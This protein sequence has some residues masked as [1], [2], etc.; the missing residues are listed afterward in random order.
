VVGRLRILSALTGGLL[1]G[2]V[3]ITVLGGVAFGAIAGSRLQAEKMTES[4]GSIS[5]RWASGARDSARASPSVTVPTGTTVDQ[6]QLFTRQASANTAEFAIYVDGTAAANKVGTFRPPA[7][8]TWGISTVNL[9][10]AIGPGVHTLYIGP[11][12]TFSNN[13]FIDW[14]KLHN[15]GTT[16]PSTDTDTDGVPDSSD[17]C[18]AVANA[19]QADTD[20]DSVGDAC[21]TTQPPTGETTVNVRDFGATGDGTSNDT[22][23]FERAMA[24]AARVG[25]VAYV[26]APGNYRIANVNPPSNTRLQVQA[27][28]S[29]KKYGSDNG[30]LFSVHGP[31]DTTF[32]NNVHIEGVGGTFNIDLSDAGSDT[33]GIRYRNVRNFSLRNMICIQN[34]DNPSQEDPS[35][36]K[37]CIS[38]LPQPAGPVNGVYNHPID[39]V[40]E[41][42][43]S[44]RSPYGWGLTQIS[45]GENVRFFD[46]SSEGGVPLRL[47]NYSNN[48]TPMSNI[49][50]DGVTC[51]DGHDAVH[52]NP[53]GARHGKVTIR[54]VVADSCESALSLKGDGSFGADST[55]TG[56]TVIP[57]NQA[58]LRDEATTG[59]VGAWVIGP[60]RW[61]IDN[62]DPLGYTISLLNVDCGDLSNRRP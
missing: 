9:S 10:T 12:A 51:K 30:P 6:I 31:N 49:V 22:E 32:V 14:F 34:N 15:L 60:S 61:C 62:D 1:L 40:L 24:Q 33:A 57:G 21:G 8:S 42:I 35:S 20:G 3:V 19:D 28:A 11:N 2:L 54:N 56:V 45:G 48:W 44:I 26:P 27:G 7:G 36:R 47:E 52:M 46:I 37:P 50:A 16:P 41:N 55:I 43:H 18:P 29:L 59:Y 58:Q 4:S 5:V 13:A 38:F 17:N 23:A 25:G 39:G 53:H